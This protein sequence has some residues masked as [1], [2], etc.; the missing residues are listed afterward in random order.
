MAPIRLG[1]GTA[2]D[3]SGFQEARTYDGT[4]LWSGGPE[5]NGPSGDWTLIV[6]DEFDSGSLDTTLWGINGGETENPLN[7]D[8]DTDPALV[9]VA[10]DT[11]TL[12][13]QSDGS[14]TGGCFQGPISTYPGSQSFH[15]DE[16]FATGNDPG[17]Y[18]ETRAQLAGPRNGLLPAFWMNGVGSSAWPPEIDIYELFQ[19]SDTPDT[20]TTAHSGH[21]TTSEEPGD[22]DN[23][24]GMGYDYTHPDDTTANMHVYGSAWFQD[25]VEFWIDG[26]KIATL[27][28]LP[29]LRTM[30]DADRNDMY[31]KFTTHVN[32]VGTADLSTAWTEQST[33][34][35][36]R[37][38]R[39]DGTPPSPPTPPSF[40]T[41]DNFDGGTIATGWNDPAGA[42]TTDS[43][44]SNSGSHSLSNTANNELIGWEGT[45]AFNAGVT[46]TRLE[47]DFTFSGTTNHRLNARFGATGATDT[48]SY[49]LDILN[50]DVYLYET[51]NWAALHHDSGFSGPAAG[52]FY[53]AEI[54]WTDHNIRYEIRDETGTVVSTHAIYHT[55]SYDGGVFGLNAETGTSY[56]DEVRV[57]SA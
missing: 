11:C 23:H 24:L 44:Y 38:W 50:G 56:I 5:P 46:G 25:R 6:Q 12:Q 32:R 22:L 39:F 45:P 1:D 31:L 16:G 15:A 30:N 40:S 29:M 20:T 17:V 53:T 8:A 52:T 18:I 19:T 41:I 27:D 36:V 4:V 57:A 54:E 47:Y 7:D 43:T 48:E 37:V 21:W 9:S 35:Y 49:R 33:I 55:Q 42:W 13:V 51:T 34:D 14:G 10:N 26:V 2:V 3:A 28:L